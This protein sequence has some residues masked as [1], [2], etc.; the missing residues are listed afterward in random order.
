[1]GGRPGGGNPGN[2][3]TGL[4]AGFAFVR[5]VYPYLNK[6]FAAMERPFAGV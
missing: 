3:V 2:V 6:G 4:L 1:M 5:L